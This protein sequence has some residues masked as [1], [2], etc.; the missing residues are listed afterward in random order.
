VP[1][2]QPALTP[3]P[4]A[5]GVRRRDGFLAVWVIAGLCTAVEVALQLADAGVLPVSRLRALAYEYG[6]FWPGLLRDWRPNFPGQS[7]AMFATYAL[8]HAGLMHLAMNMV[9]LVSLGC[10][11]VRRVGQVRFLLVYGLSALGGAVGFGLLAPT[12]RPMV[13]ASGAL[14]GL[15][16]ALAVWEW[17]ARRE[18]GL[19]VGPVLRFVLFLVLLNI[20]L[21]WAMQ[22]Q[23]AW[24]THLG[25]F[26]AG[27]AAAAAIRARAPG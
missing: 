8:L 25:G 22:G 27:A 5:E 4:V 14:F 15:A 7:V 24:E 10:E 11:A 18:E 9:T 23:L 21:W 16:G 2:D 6:G 17:Q 26:L 1:D 12:L 13:G 19:P 20:G 3:A